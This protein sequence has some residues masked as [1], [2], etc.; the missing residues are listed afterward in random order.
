M[1]LCQLDGKLHDETKSQQVIIT[2]KNLQNIS[3]ELTLE[4]CYNC[5]GLCNIK[6]KLDKDNKYM[7]EPKDKVQIYKITSSH[8]EN[9]DIKDKEKSEKKVITDILS[10]MKKNINK[11]TKK[12]KD[13]LL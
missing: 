3:K 10:I 7:I 13:V 9:K 5:F 11:N 6:Y 2:Q 8:F 12:S 4:I 1:F